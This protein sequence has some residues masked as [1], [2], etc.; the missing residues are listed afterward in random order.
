VFDG[1]NRYV[2]IDVI[3]NCTLRLTM[4]SFK[5]KDIGMDCPFEAKTKTEDEL[6]R[7]ISAHA[8]SM[9]G[10]KTVPPDLMVKIKGAIKT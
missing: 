9:H 4:P 8:A 3:A 2:Y 1:V 5:C 7:M 6:M 10:I